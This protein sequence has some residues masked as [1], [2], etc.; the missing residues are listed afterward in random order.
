MLHTLP[1]CG[2]SEEL[3]PKRATAYC[4]HGTT[5]TG[6]EARLGVAAS[7]EKSLIGKKIAMY[8]RLPDGSQGKIIGWYSVEDTG[9]MSENVIDVFQEDL[10]ACQDFMNKVYEDGCGGKVY[11][12]I[13]AD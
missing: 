13:I 9:P 1:F 4:L 2:S 5:Y 8:Q 11:I 3:I 7:S 6:T 10:E 12:K